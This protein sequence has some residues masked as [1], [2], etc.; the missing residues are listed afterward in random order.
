MLRAL[1]TLLVASYLVCFSGLD[2]FDPKEIVYEIHVGPET[3]GAYSYL[4][5]DVDVQKADDLKSVF[6][7]MSKNGAPLPLRMK[8]STAGSATGKLRVKILNVYHMDLQ[9]YSN[10]FQ[11]IKSFEELVNALVAMKRFKNLGLS[12]RSFAYQP[13]TRSFVFIDLD[14][15][16]NLDP[17]EAKEA[18]FRESMATGLFSSLSTDNIPL[19]PTDLKYFSDLKVNVGRFDRRFV[20]DSIQKEKKLIDISDFKFQ[21]NANN[22]LVFENTSKK[23]FPEVEYSA[24]FVDKS[25]SIPPAKR[26]RAKYY[27]QPNQFTNPSYF[28]Y[29]SCKQ[30]VFYS[31]TDKFFLYLCREKD[32]GVTECSNIPGSLFKEEFSIYVDQSYLEAE[33]RHFKFEEDG[34]SANF[35]EVFFTL[36]PIESKKLLASAFIETVN[37]PD[38]EKEE[39]YFACQTPDRK[40]T[41]GSSSQ[42]PSTYQTFQLTSGKWAQDPISKGFAIFQSSPLLLGKQAKACVGSE[43]KMFYFKRSERTLV[44]FLDQK[45][46]MVGLSFKQRDK[47]ANPLTLEVCRNA[48]PELILDIESRKFLTKNQVDKRYPKDVVF[49]LEKQNSKKIDKFCADVFENGGYHLRL[50]LGELPKKYFF[51]NFNLQKETAPGI[52]SESVVFLGD[53][54]KEVPDFWCNNFEYPETK[55]I[56][57]FVSVAKG[58]SPNDFNIRVVYT[59]DSIKIFELSAEK[60]AV[61]SQPPKKFFLSI[62][63]KEAPK[64]L[65]D[66]I[67][68]VYLSATEVIYQLE[69]PDFANFDN[70][71]LFDGKANSL[72]ISAGPKGFFGGTS[73][74]D[75]SKGNDL[76]DGL[77]KVLS[78]VFL[79]KRNRRLVLV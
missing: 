60:A 19:T 6:D 32:G 43:K 67:K 38:V 21:E 69:L 70:K 47:E 13:S 29:T 79:K 35:F 57:I 71:I 64:D 25:R 28:E 11:L 61:I 78:Q 2:E 76:T 45:Q 65:E 58:V 8:K 20:F 52:P 72:T 53:S 63:N 41:L 18:D 39:I 46:E 75:I 73:A 1:T 17:T 36:R 54:E 22:F 16:E 66:D 44:V 27:I 49:A 34:R 3:R 42:D 51:F 15:L 62:V 10:A 26:N 14:K 9:I 74:K 24:C 30:L 50:E 12:Y 40:V 48:V 4:D 5:K 7:E 33:I 68:T 23:L 77:T 31:K 59:Q 56:V 37:V 55:P